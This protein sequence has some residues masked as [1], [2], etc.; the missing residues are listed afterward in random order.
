MSL[1]RSRTCSA[2]K[3]NEHSKTVADYDIKSEQAQRKGA[4]KSNRLEAIFYDI[5]MLQN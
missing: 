3:I 4:G 1:K 5:Y 2:R